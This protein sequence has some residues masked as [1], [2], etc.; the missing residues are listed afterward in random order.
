MSFTL[1]GWRPIATGQAAVAADARDRYRNPYAFAVRQTGRLP[2]APW[3]QG[4]GTTLIEP[5]PTVNTSPVDQTT[6]TA[7]NYW[8]PTRNY[9]PRNWTPHLGARASYTAWGFP[10]TWFTLRLPLAQ[11]DLQT[12]LSRQTRPVVQKFAAAGG[13]AVR[14]PAVFV[15]VRP[16]G[17]GQAGGTTFE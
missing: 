12:A 17:P 5:V 15:P 2:E 14:I 10:S 1:P 8:K 16:T 9:C 11:P 3:Y 13:S 7:P 4:N 6:P